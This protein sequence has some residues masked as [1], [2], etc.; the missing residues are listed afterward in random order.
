MN[1]ACVLLAAGAGKRFGGD[2]LL[3]PVGGVPMA[4]L[5]LERFAKLPFCGRVCVTRAEAGFIRAEA[6]RR[7]YTIAINPDPARGMGTSAAIGT[8]A[9]ERLCRPDGILYAVCD[10]PYLG[11]A[12]VLRL[13][14]AFSAAPERIASL[15]FGGGRGNPAIFPREFFPELRALSADVGGGAVI[16]NHGDRLLLVEADSARELADIDTRAEEAT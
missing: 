11:E 10:Q 14:E 7:G 1:V 9:A 13:L 2:K 8:A 6:G 3:H 12:S 16:R 15:S 4:V 5:A